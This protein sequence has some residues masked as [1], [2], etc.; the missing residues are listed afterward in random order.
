MLMTR[1]FFFHPRENEVHTVLGI[2]NLFGEASGLKTNIQKSSVYP[3]RCGQEELVTLHDWLPC[4]LSSFPCKYLGL[5]LSLKK[6]SKNQVQPIID[7]VAD[8]LCG[9]KADLMTRA[10]EECRFSM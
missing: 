5:P 3:I 7:K 4:E 10:G 9:W 1:F 6:L 2:L 8:Q